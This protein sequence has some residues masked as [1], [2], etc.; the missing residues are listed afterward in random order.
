MVIVLLGLPGCGKGTQSERLERVFNLQHIS[1]GDLLRSAVKEGTAPGLAASKYMSQGLLVPDEIVVAILEQ[2]ILTTKNTSNNNGYVLDGF[3]RTIKQAKHLQ[4][5]LDK[6]WMPLKHVLLFDISEDVLVERV[7]GRLLHPASG[8]T[9]HVLHHPPK[10]AMK[11]D[12]TGEPLVKRPDDNPEALK[13]RLVAYHEQTNP[14]IEYYEEQG[15]LTRIDAGK[16]VEVVWQNIQ[17][18]LAFDFKKQTPV[19]K[20]SV[21][22]LYELASVEQQ[23]QRSDANATGQKSALL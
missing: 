18:I 5:L 9:Y 4:V 7:C 13:A 10:V 12:V 6:L 3:P 22:Q 21:D 23:Q 19:K 16:E 11:D 8:R 20:R 15:L 17:D 14:L 2:A 1:T